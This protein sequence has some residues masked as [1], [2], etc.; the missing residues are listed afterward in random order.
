MTG[1]RKQGICHEGV[2]TGIV[3]DIWRLGD[4]CQHSLQADDQRDTGA[5]H[6]QNA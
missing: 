6:D 5:A 2:K 4:R 3:D 1:R